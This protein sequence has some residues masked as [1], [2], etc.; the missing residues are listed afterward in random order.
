MIRISIS[1]EAYDA[2]ARTL[3][4]GS[5]AVE[6]E[7]NERGERYVWLDDV[8]GGPSRSL[9]RAGRR[10]FGGDPAADSVRARRRELN[11]QP[12]RL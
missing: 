9:A 7:A 11:P 12:L 8:W 10:L 6:A 2:I 4:F 1:T 5:V 3:P